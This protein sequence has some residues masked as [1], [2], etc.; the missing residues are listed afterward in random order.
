MLTTEQILRRLDEDGI[1][2][3]VHLYHLTFNGEFE[4]SISLTKQADG[5]KIRVKEAR[6]ESSFED[7]L[8]AAWTKYESSVNIGIPVLSAPQLEHQG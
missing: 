2:V 3:Y 1:E 7:V 4:W 5:I 6:R 8:A